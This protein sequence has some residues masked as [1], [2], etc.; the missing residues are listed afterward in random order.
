MY[1]ARAGAREVL[2]VDVSAPALNLARENARLNE[3]GNVHFAQGDVFDQLAA[4][5]ESGAQFGLIVLDPPKFARTPQ[6][7]MA[8]LRGYR[9]LQTLAL[10]LLESDGILVTCCCS[11]LISRD[12]LEDM[13]S[14]LAA[15]NKRR[16]Q[17]LEVRGQAPDHPVAANCLEA[18]YLKCL[19]CRVV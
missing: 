7:V 17:I 12:M 1:A 8:A 16:I 4:L 10:R 5:L 11:G 2:G 15:E 19:I 9:R 13:L 14:Q 18:N 6:A 3:L